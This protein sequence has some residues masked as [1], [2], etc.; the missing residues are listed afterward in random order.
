MTHNVFSIETT[1]LFKSSLDRSR[2][3]QKKYEVLWL[4]GKIHTNT[5]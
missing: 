5:L 2:G 4:E 3:K 1:Y